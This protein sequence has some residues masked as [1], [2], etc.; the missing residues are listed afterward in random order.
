MNKYSSLKRI[1]KIAL[2]ILR[3]NGAV[4]AGIFGSYARGEQTKDSDLDLLVRLKSGKGFFDL[5]R[6]ERELKLKLNPKVDLITYNSINHLLKERI[7]KEE[8]RIL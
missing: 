4:K 8:V 5:I 3:K 1:I 2:P 7:L 6:L